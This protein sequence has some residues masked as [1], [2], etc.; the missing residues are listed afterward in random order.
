[1]ELL[2]I[3]FTR[4][5][6]FNWSKIFLVSLTL[7][8]LGGVLLVIPSFFRIDKCVYMCVCVYIYTHFDY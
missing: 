1:M 3:V 6:E 4:K 8:I 2:F 7:I 5:F